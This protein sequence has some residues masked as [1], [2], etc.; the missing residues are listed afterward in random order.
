VDF[1]LYSALKGKKKDQG[2]NMTNQFDIIDFQ[3]GFCIKNVMLYS[4]AELLH[5]CGSVIFLIMI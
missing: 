3:K 1:C 5:E 2:L 4:V